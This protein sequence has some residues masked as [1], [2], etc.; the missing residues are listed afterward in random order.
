MKSFKQDLRESIERRYENNSWMKFCKKTNPELYNK[1]IS[2]ILKKENKNY[3]VP[4]KKNKFLGWT[5][6]FA[7]P[8][9]IIALVVITISII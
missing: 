2:R 9:S 1:E 3:F 5:L 4:K 7:N 8:I 6:N